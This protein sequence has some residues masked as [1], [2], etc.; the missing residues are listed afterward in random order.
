MGYCMYQVDAKFNIPREK[1]ADALEAV[2]ALAK[3]TMDMILCSFIGESKTASRYSWV[4][5]NF[6]ESENLPDI[7]GCWRWEVSLNANYDVVGIEFAGEKSGQDMVLWETL[8]PFV[9][10]GSFIHMQGEDGANWRWVFRDGIVIEE[11]S[12]HTWPDG[13][14][15]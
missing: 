11:Y 8:A 14:V 12:T 1:H 7:I 6:A 13:T 9:E 3:N 10:D 5:K 2:K 4:A 15:V